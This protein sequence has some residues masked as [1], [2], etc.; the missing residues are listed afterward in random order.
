[1]K[2]IKK[3]NKNNRE[4][5]LHTRVEQNIKDL[6]EE[7]ALKTERSVGS[8]VRQFIK[9]GLKRLSSKSTITKLI[10]TSHE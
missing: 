7:E 1:M 5:I 3:T 10:S 2:K 9:E 8:L 6:L 4:K